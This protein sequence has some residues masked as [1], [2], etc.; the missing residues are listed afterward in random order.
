MKNFEQ[1]CY[2]IR[3]DSRTGDVEF[4]LYVGN[5]LIGIYTREAD[6]RRGAARYAGDPSL[7]LASSWEEGVAYA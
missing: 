6:A 1:V 5:E 2:S 7:R 4:D 3:K